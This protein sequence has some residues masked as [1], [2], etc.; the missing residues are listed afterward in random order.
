M[1]ICLIQ[2]AKI[3]WYRGEV[4]VSNAFDSVVDINPKFEDVIE[5]TKQMLANDLLLA[6]I[7]PKDEKKIVQKQK[8]D[9]TEIEVRHISEILLSG[10]DPNKETSSEGLST[11]FS[12]RKEEDADLLDMTST[13]KKLCT[14]MIKL[15]KIT[16][17][18]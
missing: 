16:T 13:S 6:L 15:E 2:F 8:Q 9:W 4:Q 10:V 11:T 1:V 12:K 14:K 5:F 18:A 3:G 17:D 7:V